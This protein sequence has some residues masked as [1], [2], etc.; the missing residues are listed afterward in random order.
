VN[1][2]K[3]ETVG[4]FGLYL[5]L[6]LIVACLGLYTLQP[7]L[8]EPANIRTFFS[9]NLYSGLTVY[10][11]IC[12]LRGLTLI[13]ST[14]FV[15]AGILVFP[16]LPLFL[17]NQVAVYSSS[18][19]LYYTTRSMRFDNFFFTHYPQQVERLITLLRKRELPVISLWGFAPFIPTDMIVCICS[20]LRIN[21]WK[22]LMG[23]SLGEGI[24]C[25]IY[26]FGGSATLAALM[27]YLQI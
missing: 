26:I 27:Q 16:P 19:V 20:V 10:L 1:K 25:A 9:D 21:V 11:V 7:E 8:F 12:T 23:V 3:F 14:P 13:P 15:L 18:A 22:T 17:V 2:D 24:I 5:W 4:S 6:A